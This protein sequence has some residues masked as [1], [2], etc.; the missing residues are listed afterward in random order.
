[1]LKISNV[2]LNKVI[3]FCATVFMIWTP[4]LGEASSYSGKTLK[5]LSFRDNHSDA[6]KRNLK[7]FE[8]ATGAKVIF[9]AVASNT[10]AAKTATDQLGGGSYDLYTVDEP[11]M[12]RLSTFFDEVSAWPDTTIYKKETEPDVF[13][14]AALEGGSYLGKQYGIPVNGNVY[15]YVYRSDLF[16]SKDEQIA[17]KA[18][19][20]YSLSVPKT[21]KEFRDVAE[22]FTRPP[23][24]YGF[25]PFTKKS[26]GTTVEAIWILSTFGVDVFSSAGELVFDEGK[27]AKAFGFYKELMGFAP[28][29]ASSW[30][31]AERMA[32]YS[33]GK[34]AQIMTWPSFV[35][36][37]EDPRKSLVVGKNKYGLPP[38]GESGA[39]SPVAGSW[40]LAIPK[41]SKNK[42]LAAEFARWWT[43]RDTSKELVAFGMNPARVDVLSDSQILKSNPHFKGVLENFQKAKVRPR[44]QGY[45]EVSD[46][47]STHFTAMIAGFSTPSAAASAL[48]KDLKMLTKKT[49]FSKAK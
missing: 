15:M 2:F 11:F 23:K 46:K 1:M 17:F 35:K 9:D 48:A 30:H 47:I 7:K 20:G 19:Y 5:V 18:R 10:V 14:K 13:L 25:A 34:I 22:F 45:K 31:H 28:R 33:A 40:T 4:E 42:S 49:K 39:P 12:P 41:S 24:M 37:L 26:E 27:A 16:E 44:F 29:G 38:A 8:S 21:V 36:G 6:V 32:R 3:A 43:G